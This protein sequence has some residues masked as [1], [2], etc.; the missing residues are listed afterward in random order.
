MESRVE[1]LEDML[2]MSNPDGGREPRT[3]QCIVELQ[4][5][6]ANFKADMLKRNKELEFFCE[7]NKKI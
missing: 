7:K 1:Y 3:P 2:G 6:F 5:S 4:N